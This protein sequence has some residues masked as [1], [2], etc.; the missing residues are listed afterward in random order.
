MGVKRKDGKGATWN[1]S[2]K[3]GKITKKMG[4]NVFTLK[5][6]SCLQIFLSATT[7]SLHLSLSLMSYWPCLTREENLHLSTKLAS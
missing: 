4:K 2:V 6:G 7:S 1:E 3:K 5:V